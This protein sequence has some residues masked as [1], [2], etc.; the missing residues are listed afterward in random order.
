MSTL[1]NNR[2]QSL[3]ITLDYVKNHLGHPFQIIE[4]TDEEIMKKV[5]HGSAMTIF[6]NFV[7]HFEILY[8][9][10]KDYVGNTGRKQQLDLMTITTADPAL[11]FVD[12]SLSQA[13]QDKLQVLKDKLI[14]ERNKEL[15]IKERFI[16]VQNIMNEIGDIE[17]KL[18]NHSTI[19][20]NYTGREIL[21]QTKCR[22]SY[23]LSTIPAAKYDKFNY[24]CL[25]ELAKLILPIRK[26][27]AT[28]ETPLG[29]LQPDVE[30]PQILVDSF[31]EFI[32]SKFDVVRNVSVNHK[33]PM[34]MFDDGTI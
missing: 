16:S 9:T 5:I 22:H 18:I 13:K 2:Y 17:Y 19:L 14:L 3:Q 30:T 26:F 27:N 15:N 34:V 23:D 21:V 8:Y 11:V 33:L 25:L 6:S 31:E 7:P 32:N 12:P 10:E 4:L 24:L 1:T 20:L 29:S 28:I